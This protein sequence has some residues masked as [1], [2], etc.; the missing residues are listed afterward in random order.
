MPIGVKEWVIAEGYIPPESHGP[1]PEMTSHETVCILNPSD[2]NA[3]IEITFL[4]AAIVERE[5]CGD[6]RTRNGLAVG[7]PR[8]R[9]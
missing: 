5:Q 6:V 1:E 8:E 7:T 4:A 3:E 2:Q 9:G